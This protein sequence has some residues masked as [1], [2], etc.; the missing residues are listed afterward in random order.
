MGEPIEAHPF[1]VST[2]ISSPI[3]LCMKLLLCVYSFLF[4]KKMNIYI[5]HIEIDEK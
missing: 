3:F 4:F 1:L 5:F 2:S